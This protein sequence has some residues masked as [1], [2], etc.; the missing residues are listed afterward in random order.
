MT[1]PPS[2]TGQGIGQ[3]PPHYAGRHLINPRSKICEPPSPTNLYRRLSELIMRHGVPGASIAVLAGSHVA[4]A[5]A[6]VL[7]TNTRVEATEDSVFQI[8]S[9]TKVYTTTLVMQLIDE[10]KVKLDEPVVTVL[11]GLQ[12]A[13]HEVTQTVTLR[14]LLTH[15]SGI[16]GDHVVDSGR[17]DDAVARYVA[18]CAEL[19]QTHPLG[20]MMSYCNSGF[21]IAG[22]VVEELTGQT[23]DEA[24]AERLLVPLGL[25]RTLTLPE[26]VLLFR[27]AVGHVDRDGKTQP[28]PRWCLPRGGGPAG[29][30]CATA[31]DV[32]QFV[33]MHLDGGVTPDGTRILSSEC[34][35]AMLEPYV[36][37]PV[38]TPLLGSHR[39]LGWVLNDWG[40]HR[41][42]GHNGAT[43]GQF[44]F[45]W[46]MPDDDIAVV[47]LT[48]GGRAQDLFADL[49][50][51]LLAEL[52]GV[53]TPL[54]L[55]PPNPRVDVKPDEYVG[56]YERRGLRLEIDRR[57]GGLWVRAIPNGSMAKAFAQP[58]IELELIAVSPDVFVTRE[59]GVQSWVPIV[60]RRLDDGSRYV[61]FGGRATPKIL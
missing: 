36:A 5:A 51:P 47:L 22:R 7:N 17:G 31:A 33:R 13:D 18:S 23:W 28:A 34:V 58:V 14:H 20:A 57:D 49:V 53:E 3:A 1:E 19:G 44:A 50:P 35:A 45:L 27:A 21:V 2:D 6:G 60:F 25:S 8:G 12:L 48:N 9:I 29:L 4:G 55:E 54:P 24:L 41:V 26:D 16:E 40:G 32:L 46:V 39:G 30:I 42:C 52:A 11:P 56:V 61:H 43:V 37:L 59:P 38:P 15:T 10:G